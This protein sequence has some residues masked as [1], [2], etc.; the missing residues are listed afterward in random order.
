M[1]EW[2]GGGAW[3]EGGREEQEEVWVGIRSGGS[4]HGG[5]EGGALVSLPPKMVP[6]S[7]Y[8]GAPARLD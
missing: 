4:Q 3:D 8:P 5:R 1:R 6:L 7:F 2:R